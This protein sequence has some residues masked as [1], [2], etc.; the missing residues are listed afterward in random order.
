MIITKI[1]NTLEGI[2]ELMQEQLKILYNLK[3]FV[4]KG[5]Q[6]KQKDDKWL[7]RIDVNF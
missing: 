6:I 5:I 2:E 1:S 4:V 3:G 7:L